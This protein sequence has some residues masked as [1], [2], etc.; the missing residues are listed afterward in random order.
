MAKTVVMGSQKPDHMRTMEGPG[1]EKSLWGGDVV[2][3]CKDLKSFPSKEG[4]APA[5]DP[6]GQVGTAA[7]LAQYK[8]HHCIDPETGEGEAT[9]EI[10]TFQAEVG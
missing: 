8:K 10:S 7:D 3:N 2:A 9:W 6:D 5:D 1:E 4:L